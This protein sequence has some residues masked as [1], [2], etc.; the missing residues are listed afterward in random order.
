MGIHFTEDRRGV[1]ML[2]HT[3]YMN[4]YICTKCKGFCGHTRAPLKV[5]R[6]NFCGI[7]NKT[8]QQVAEERKAEP[9]KV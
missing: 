8:T 7:C 6:Y 2:V 1:T 3:G 5:L 4:I 9:V